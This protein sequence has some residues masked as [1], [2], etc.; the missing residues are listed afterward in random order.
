MI[1]YWARTGNGGTRAGTFIVMGALRG[2]FGPFG[3]V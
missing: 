2:E 1:N 3:A